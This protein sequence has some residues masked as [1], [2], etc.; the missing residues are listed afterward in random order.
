MKASD[1]AL[2][3]LIACWSPAS[4]GGPTFTLDIFIENSD[5]DLFFVDTQA[6]DDDWS[7]AID[8]LDNNDFRIQ[9]DTRSTY[10]IIIESGAGTN[11]LYL[12]AFERIGINTNDPIEELDIRSAVPA[13]RLDDTSVGAGQVDLMMSSNSFIIEG[14]SGLDMVSIDTRAPASSLVI[15]S[16]GDFSLGGDLFID[17][18]AARVG[19]NTSVPAVELD[20][21]ASSP[22]IRLDDTSGG[23]GQVD[24]AMSENTFSIQ[25]N[26]GVNIVNID[27]RAPSVSLTITEDGQ[28]E[29]AGQLFVAEQGLIGIGVENPT[30]PLELASGAHIS[31]GGAWMHSSSREHK[32]NIRALAGA[33]AVDAL[34]ALSPVKFNYKAEEGEEHVG[35]IAEDAPALVATS[36]RKSLSSMDIAAVLTKVVQQQ[37]EQLEA[38]GKRL[39]EQ[40]RIIEEFAHN[41]G[42]FEREQ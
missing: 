38:Q 14:E 6:N 18:S 32:E 17:T 9:N 21:R 26:A 27:T 2:V 35:F 37:Q 33:E 40:Q 4:A 28:V 3:L 30:H 36:S 42:A 12:D 31:A 16:I 22:E 29:L 13:I 8:D 15:D 23:Q 25:G 5:P 10:P 1:L 19:I 20:V 39:D 11:L 34:G 41:L 7:I 24:L